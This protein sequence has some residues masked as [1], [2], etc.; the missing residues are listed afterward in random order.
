VLFCLVAEWGVRLKYERR[1][2]HCVGK[3][4]GGRTP[5]GRWTTQQTVLL[6]STAGESCRRSSLPEHECSCL[7][8]VAI[9]P[10]HLDQMFSIRMCLPALHQACKA[11]SPADQGL[12]TQVPLEL[13]EIAAKRPVRALDLGLYRFLA[14]RSRPSAHGRP[15]ILG[16]LGQGC[17]LSKGAWAGW[18]AG[19]S[20]CPCLY[21]RAHSLR[22]Q[23]MNQD[24]TT[25]S[26][27]QQ[28]PWGM[29]RKTPSR[30]H[31]GVTPCAHHAMTC[32]RALDSDQNPQLPT[33]TA[34]QPF[35]NLHPE[36]RTPS[37]SEA[38]IAPDAN[39][40]PPTPYAPNPYPQKQGKGGV[41]CKQCDSRRNPQPPTLKPQPPTP[42]L[43]PGP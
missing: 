29:K 38:S 23:N 1:C 11:C 40:E 39:T 13:F 17:E 28:W 8:F 31:L 36:T 22:E 25:S 34:I 3:E 16:A 7:L 10:I 42:N 43:N 26:Q 32:I 6:S 20:A 27:K 35:P 19:H 12:F 18:R 41:Q 9:W 2:S 21:A 33:L 15:C 24:S 14:T 30:R 4:G 37:R 5:G